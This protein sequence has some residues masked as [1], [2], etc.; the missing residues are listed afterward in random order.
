MEK[1]KIIKNIYIINKK[2][3]STFTMTKKNEF[4]SKRESERE[5]KRNGL[6]NSPPMKKTSIHAVLMMYIFYFLILNVFYLFLIISFKNI[7]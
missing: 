1:V 3:T 5:T 4:K 2:I 7:I 6:C